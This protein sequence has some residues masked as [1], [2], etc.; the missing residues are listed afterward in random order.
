[1]DQE[2]IRAVLEQMSEEQLV[3]ILLFIRSLQTECIEAP[4]AACPPGEQPV[5]E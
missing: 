3:D 4:P 1:M 5:H 2:Q